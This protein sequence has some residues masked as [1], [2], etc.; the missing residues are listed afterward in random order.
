MV[1]IGGGARTQMDIEAALDLHIPV[2]PAAAGGK[3]AAYW[4][5]MSLATSSLPIP[6]AD[7]SQAR[8][9]WAVLADTD[10][11]SVAFAIHRLTRWGSYLE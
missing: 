9:H 7:Q 10:V 5:T 2:V 3:A 11:N 6:L 1:V 4:A 8:R